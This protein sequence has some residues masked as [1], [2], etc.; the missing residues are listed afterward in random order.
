M[1]DQP[2][3]PRHGC[4]FY[5]AIIALV[6]VF[7]L[8]TTLFLGYRL[9]KN[10]VIEYTDTTPAPLPTVQ[11][12]QPELERLQARVEAFREAVRAGQRTGPLTL[13]ADELNALIAA[14]PDLQ[15]LKGKL[16]VIIEGNQLK[17]KI[18]LPL[19]QAGVSMLKGRYL[20]G[21]ANLDVSLHDGTLK[22]TPQSLVTARGKS[23]PPRLMEK[24]RNQNLARKANL[25][26]K[27]SVA[28]DRIESIKITDGT[29]TVVPRPNE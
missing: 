24:L 6:I 17:G 11:L 3:K 1:P 18:A 15:W 10:T 9:V 26:P 12:S 22:V 21:T 13:S 28:L 27:A 20:N 7:L 19:E 14:N 25:D 4:V 8:L 16:Y 2:S 29:V 5:G 23:L